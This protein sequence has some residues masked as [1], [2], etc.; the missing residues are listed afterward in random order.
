MYTTIERI[1][2]LSGF[3]NSSN[4]TDE[5]IKSKIIIASGMVDSAIG[6]LYSLPLSYRY[7]NTLTFSGTATTGTMNITINGTDYPLSVTA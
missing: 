3:D 2:T 5:N 1:R 7:Q 6:Y 4:I